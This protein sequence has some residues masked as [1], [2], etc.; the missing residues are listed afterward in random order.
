MSTVHQLLHSELT[1]HIIGAYFEVYNELGA[2]FRES[3]Y[4]RALAIQLEALDFKVDRQPKISIRYREQPV[5]IFRGDLLEMSSSS[6]NS[7]PLRRSN[8]LMRRN[9]STVSEQLRS[10]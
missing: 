5:G 6:S 4:E 7:K 10:R 3:V 9:C 8:L 2:G 1:G